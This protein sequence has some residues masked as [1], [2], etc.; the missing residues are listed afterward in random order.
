MLRV[1]K[2][3]DLYQWEAV[4]RVYIRGVPSVT[5]F[6]KA[7]CHASNRFAYCYARSVATSVHQRVASRDPNP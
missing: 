3:D 6:Q 5:R 1:M 7:I 4:Y 2:S